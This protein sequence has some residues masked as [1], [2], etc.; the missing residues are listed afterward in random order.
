MSEEESSSSQINEEE[1]KVVI[2]P[3]CDVPICYC[4]FFGHTHKINENG[5]E[6]DVIEEVPDLQKLAKKKAGKKENENKQDIKVIIKSRTKRKKITTIENMEDWDIDVKDFSKQISKKMAIGCSTQKSPTGKLQV[7]VQ[8]DA[9]IP[10]I[11]ILIKQM[12]IPKDNIKAIRKE[13]K[14]PVEDPHQPPPQ[15]NR[16]GN[17]YSDDDYNDDDDSEEEKPQNKKQQNEH[18]NQKPQQQ[19]KK[20]QNEHQNQKSQQQNKKQQN[21]HQNKK[22]NEH[23]DQKPQQQNKK[24]QNEHQNKKQN[25][26]QDQKPQQQNREA[27][28]HK[29]GGHNNN[30]RGRGR[31]GR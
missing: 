30:N 26:H 5:E 6:T 17:E 25:E 14:A 1:N 20:Q 3:R 23:Q 8:G 27:Q 24:Q 19:N 18:Q 2:C 31:G 13:K 12:K 29:R 10:V 28:Q 15:P 16:G 4:Q 21:E 7:V 9:S 11:E 22:Q